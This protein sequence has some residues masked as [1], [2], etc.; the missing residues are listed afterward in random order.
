MVR[1]FVLLFIGFGA[2]LSSLLASTPFPASKID[3]VI[4]KARTYYGTKYKWG[5]ESYRGLDCSGLIVVSFRAAGIQIAH[6]SRLQAK[7]RR[8]K[9]VSKD[10]LQQGDLLFFSGGGY[11]IG[12][13]AMVTEVERGR[14]KFI[15]SSSNNGRVSYNY[16]HERHWRET[17]VKAKRFFKLLSTKKSR[18]KT[19]F[20]IVKD[21]SNNQSNPS[22]QIVKNKSNNQYQIHIQYHSNHPPKISL[23]DRKYPQA[24]KRRLSKCDLK[25]MEPCEVKI[26]KNEIY[27]Q[28]GYEFH[29]NGTMIT[30]FNQLEWYRQMPKISSDAGYIFRN[31]MT[32]TERHNVQLLVNYEG[33]CN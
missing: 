26:M 8:G 15:H 6:N 10:D 7:D 18:S 27:A 20:Q 25:G 5:G 30:Y 11:N 21:K 22:F 32:R 31:Y 16:L 12:H 3:K 4:Q 29:Q 19:N 1:I 33:S 2:N 17:Y 14:I 9:E 24:S 23:K 13:V 28:Y